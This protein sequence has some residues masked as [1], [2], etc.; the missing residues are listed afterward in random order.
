M[1]KDGE[2]QMAGKLAL[3]SHFRLVA[4]PKEWRVTFT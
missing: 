3:T 1:A 2:E 4:I